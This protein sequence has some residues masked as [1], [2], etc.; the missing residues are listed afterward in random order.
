VP[1]AVLKASPYS[2]PWGYFIY[3]KVSA[4][5]LVGISDYSPVGNGALLLTLPDAPTDLANVE[6][7][8]NKD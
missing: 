1:I 6:S 5:N 7:I 4:T 8:T 3:A 2:I